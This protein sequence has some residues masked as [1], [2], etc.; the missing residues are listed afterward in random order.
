MCF[1]LEIASCTTLKQQF[2][3]ILVIDVFGSSCIGCS[4]KS[5][6]CGRVF[7]TYLDFL[8]IQNLV[9]SLIFLSML[10]P[11]IA[12]HKTVAN[13]WLRITWKTHE[14]ASI[15]RCQK[16]RRSLNLL[17]FLYPSRGDSMEYMRISLN[18]RLR[19]GGMSLGYSI[20]II[21]NMLNGLVGNDEVTI[22]RYSFRGLSIIWH[23]R[24]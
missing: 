21:T 5:F 12:T 2:G 3:S 10:S 23:D 6:Q 1:L 24:I 4:T 7:N 16:S 8:V 22:R 11:W 14:F 19:F 15:V 9:Y 13:I 18:G 20:T 17:L